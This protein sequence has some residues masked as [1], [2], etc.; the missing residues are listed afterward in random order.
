MPDRNLS[1][2]CAS[3]ALDF[4]QLAAEEKEEFL[5]VC[6]LQHMRELGQQFSVSHIAQSSII[7]LK[8]LNAVI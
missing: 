3:W 2:Q 4:F 8:H 7:R 6:R 5:C 1:I